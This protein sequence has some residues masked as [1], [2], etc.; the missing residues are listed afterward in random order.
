[1]YEDVRQPRAERFGRATHC[2]PGLIS[3]RPV[4]I[5]P[6]QAAVLSYISCLQKHYAVEFKDLPN[7]SQNGELRDW[8]ACR[9][10]RLE[11]ENRFL[12]MLKSFE[13]SFW[14]KPSI[15]FHHGHKTWAD[16]HR[17]ATTKLHTDIWGGEHIGTMNILLPVFDF[18]VGCEFAEPKEMIPLAPQGDYNHVKVETVPV[19]HVLKV[20]E[21]TFFD[22]MLLHKTIK[23]GE[24]FRIAIDTRGLYREQLSID[25][26]DWPSKSK[27]EVPNG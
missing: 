6:L 15:R 27:Y 20:G 16:D 24:G 11:V 17:F 4:N 13:V 22:S 8:G 3:S 9:D 1:M 5:G 21:I 26:S 25:L 2:L 19:N 12:V 7:V 10:E 18:G 14:A 23:K